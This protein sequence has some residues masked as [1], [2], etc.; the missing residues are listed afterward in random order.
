MT[1]IY[2]ITPIV[3]Q[4]INLYPNKVKYTQTN[5]YKNR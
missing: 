1:T 3:I 2:S 4:L 5:I